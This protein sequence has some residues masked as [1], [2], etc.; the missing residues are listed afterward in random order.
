MKK[1][2][3]SKKSA[4]KKTAP[5]AAPKKAVKRAAPPTKKA[6]SW[7]P[8]GYH[9]INV[10]LA[11]DGAAAA[12]DFYKAAF[13]ARERMRM[14]MGPGKIGHAEL[15]MGDSVLMLAD[16]SAE[17]DF[18]GPKSRGGSSVTISLYVKD[19]DAVVAAA[20]KAGAAVRRPA[21][22]EFYGDRTATLEDPFG[23]I[24]HVATHKE[25][26]SEAEMVRRMEAL[27]KQVGS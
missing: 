10:Y 23:H 22:D 7:M 17:F 16:E 4:A 24:W 13:G 19:V 9:V 5:K 26:V 18:H 8:K 21:K 25:D 27:K 20:V 1:K 11:V 12:I 6:V 2:A 15:E 3:A 14:E